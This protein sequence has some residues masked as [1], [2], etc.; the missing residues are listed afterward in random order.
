MCSVNLQCIVAVSFV[1]RSAHSAL[2]TV[3]QNACCEVK[4][5]R[6]YF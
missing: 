2:A 4:D 1:G 3:Q 5:S 6:K